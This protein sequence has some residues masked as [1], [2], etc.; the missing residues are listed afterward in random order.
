MHGTSIALPPPGFLP[1]AADRVLVYVCVLTKEARGEYLTSCKS[2]NQCRGNDFPRAE[3][4]R[5]GAEAE[6]G[7]G[8]PGLEKGPPVASS[9]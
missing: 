2:V 8:S 6:F 4:R 1:A 5:A 3:E 9:L 7:S